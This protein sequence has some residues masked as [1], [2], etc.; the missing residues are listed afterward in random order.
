MMQRLRGGGFHFDFVGGAKRWLIVSAVVLAVSL[1]SLGVRQ[2]N[3]GLEFTGGTAFEVATRKPAS[4]ADLKQALATAGFAEAIVQET[5]DGSGFYVQSTHLSSD[6][7]IRAQQA[8][9][10]VAGVDPGDVNVQDVGPKWGQQITNKALRSLVIFFIVAAIFI[11][12]RLEPKM[13]GAAMVAVFHDVL[14]TAGIY[15]LT[16]FKVTQSTIIAFLTILGYSLYDTVVIFDRVK[17]RSAVLSAAGRSTYSQ[18]ANESVNQVLVRSLN[19]SITSLLPVGSLL[20]V[21]SFLL[22]AETLRELALALFIGLAAGTYS[23]IFVALPILA[24]W[25]EREARWATLRARIAARTGEPTAPAS[26][27]AP[28][29]PGPSGASRPKAGPPK[30]RRKRRRR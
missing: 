14:A 11:S 28:V 18:M 23:S 10:D 25:K 30:R 4:V 5:G 2:L 17:E 9:A 21:G 20:F 7:R 1:L 22:G 13:A 29:S 24:I 26:E 19:T 27:P 6:D 12:L 3:L 15:S 8:I 16:G